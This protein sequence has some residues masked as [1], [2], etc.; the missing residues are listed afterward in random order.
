V[1]VGKGAFLA[2]PIGIEVGSNQMILVQ[3]L[4]TC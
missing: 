4:L 1:I 2:I 3:Y